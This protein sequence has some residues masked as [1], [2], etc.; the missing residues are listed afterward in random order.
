MSSPRWERTKEIVAAA[1]ELEL[2]QRDRFLDEACPDPDIRKE[3]ESLLASEKE[4][5]LEKPASSKFEDPAEPTQTSRSV[6]LTGMTLSHYEI[7]KKLGEGGMG[8]VFLAQDRSLDRR[9]ALKLLTAKLEGDETAKKRFLREAKSAAALDHPYICKI[10]EIGEAEGKSFIAMEYVGG[11]TLQARLVRGTLPLAEARRAGSEIAEALEAA[12]QEGIVHRDLK[13][14]NIMLTPG[15]HV[16]VLDFGLAK[17]VTDPGAD[18]DSQLETESQLT[19]EGMTLGTLAYMSPEQLRNQTV[20]ARSDIFSFGI[21]L[22]EMAAGAHPFTKATSMDTAAGILNLAPPPLKRN[23]PDTPE[24]LEHIVSKMLAKE[25]EDRYQLVHEVRTDLDSLDSRAVVPEKRAP[26]LS[27]LRLGRKRFTIGAAALAALTLAAALVL[28]WNPSDGRSPARDGPP[29]VAVLPLTNISEDPLESDYLAAGISQA[30]T[31]KLTQ[32]GLRVTPWDT[33]RRYRDSD[34]P[35]EAIARELNVDAVLVGTFQIAGDQILTNI[36]LIDAESGFQSWAD[37]IVEPYEDIFRM[38]LRLA[39]GVAESLKKEL[40]G[41]EETLL[42]KPESRSVDAY[43]FYLQ[44]AHILQEGDRESTE[45]AF[46]YFAR[47][48]E[49]DPSL[50][51]A[52]EG[53]G[54]V[55][56]IRYF[57]GSGG[58]ESLNQSEERFE[59]ALELNPASMRARRGLIE[60]AF[61]RGSSEAVLIQGAEAERLGQRDDV[62]TLLARAEAYSLGGLEERSFPLLR[63]V[64]QLDPANSAALYHLVFASWVTE[65]QQA[66]DLY[67]TYVRRFGEDDVLHLLVASAHYLLGNHEKAHEYYEEALE[68]MET[69]SPDVPALFISGLFYDAMGERGRAEEVWYRGIEVT[70][71]SLESYPDNVAMRLFLASFYGLIGEHE[72]FLAESRRALEVTDM[73]AYVLPSL[74]AVHARRGESERAVEILR[75]LLHSGRIDTR[76]KPQLRMAGTSPDSPPYDQFL[77]EYEAERQRLL[78]LY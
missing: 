73:D 42:S 52:H 58:L 4:G 7:Q 48:V 31:N 21:V 43:D 70:R 10:Y 35:A 55:Q 29:S 60:V 63:H 6:D 20:D 27:M 36:S 54:A 32:V 3:V 78:E 71:L 68:G 26:I 77:K 44:G 50:A 34:R 57:S 17:R 22:Y 2:S 53:L 28:W 41:E 59:A 16:K 65:P 24:L 56:W 49:L 33:A 5:F 72:S 38:Q 25:P 15:G 74:A 75:R 69:S 45:V 39:T 30:V 37:V 76:W 11:E 1:L 46:Q 61:L 9:V 51:E 67:K 47:A 18:D 14:S 66:V 8:Q 19:G 13:P 64:I 12:H 23:R 62:E 40:T